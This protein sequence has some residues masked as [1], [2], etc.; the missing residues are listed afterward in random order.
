MYA[1]VGEDRT[2]VVGLSEVTSGHPLRYVMVVRLLAVLVTDRYYGIDLIGKALAHALRLLLPICY[3]SGRSDAINSVLS[4][5]R[6]QGLEDSSLARQLLQRKNKREGYQGDKDNYQGLLYPVPAISPSRSEQNKKKEGVAIRSNKGKPASSHEK[7]RKRKQEKQR[8]GRERGD[9]AKR[10]PHL[11]WPS[12]SLQG[13]Y[14]SSRTEGVRSAAR[15]GRDVT[16]IPSGG[17]ILPEQSLKQGFS[18]GDAL[19][20]VQAAFVATRS[21]ADCLKGPSATGDREEFVKL[22]ST[23]IDSDGIPFVEWEEESLLLANSRYR[24]SLIARFGGRRPTLKEIREWCSKAW[25]LTGKIS[26]AALRKGLIWIHFEC[27][28]DMNKVLEKGQY[29]VGKTAMFLHRWCPGLD[30]DEL[31]LSTWVVW[32]EMSGVPLEL[33]NAWGLK[34]LVLMVGKFIAFDNQTRAL[35][36]PTSVRACCEINARRKLPEEIKVKLKLRGKEQDQETAKEFLK[37]H[38]S[39]ESVAIINQFDH[40]TLEAIMIHVLATVFH[41]VKDYPIVR[42]STLIEQLDSVFRV[43]ADLLKRRLLEIYDN[44]VSTDNPGKLKQ[45]QRTLYEKQYGY[46][47]LMGEFLESRELITINTGGNLNEASL[48]SKKKG[49]KVHEAA[50]KAI[51]TASSFHYKK[52]FS[53]DEASDWYVANV[54]K[55]FTVRNKEEEELINYAVSARHPFQFISTVLCLEFRRINPLLHPVTQDASASAYQLISYFLLNKEL[56]MH[57]NLIP[58]AWFAVSMDLPVFYRIPMFTSVQDYMKTKPV[59]LWVYDRLRKKK[60]QVTLRVTTS[61]RD[62]RKTMAATFVNFIHQKDAGYVVILSDTPKR[63]EIPMTIGNAIS[64]RSDGKDLPVYARILEQVMKKYEEYGDKEISSIFIRIYLSGMKTSVMPILSDDEIAIKIWESI[65]CKVAGEVNEAI[66]IGK[67]KKKPTNYLTALKPTISQ[68]KPFIVADTETLFIDQVHVPYAAGFLVVMP[69]DEVS[70]YSSYK[71]ETYFSEDNIAN[72][73]PTFNERSQKMMY[74]LIERLVVV[75]RQNPSIQ[76]VYFHNF[77]RFDGILLLKYLATY[78]GEKYTIKPLMRNHMLYEIAVYHGKKKLFSLRDSYTLLTSS[79]D[80]L[81]KNLCPQLGC[82]GSIPYDE[83]GVDNLHLLR[84][85][86]L[87]YMKQDILL[88]G[89]VMKKAQEIY[90]GEYHIDLV[91]KL[92]LSSL[93]LTIFRTNYYDEKNWPIYI[94]NRNEDTFIRRGYYGGHSD[95]YIPYGENLYSYDVNSLYP[96]IMKSFPMPGGR[97][98]WHGHLE[99]QNLDNLFGFI[100]AHVVCPSTISRPFLPYRDDNTNTLIFPTGNFVGVYYSEEL[101]Y[102]RDIGYKINPLSGYLFEKMHNSPFG[103]FVSSVFKMRQDA[104]R[105]GNNAMSYVYKILMNSLYGRFGINP[106][107][108]VTE[109]CNLDRYN[110]L[111]M[112]EDFIYADKLSSHYYIVSYLTNTAVA[113]GTDWR[114]P[115]ISAVQL[116]A[117]I[118]ACARIHMYPYISRPDCYYT[119]TDSVVLGSPLPEG[120]ISSTVLGKFKLEH[121]IKKG[122]FLAPK[123]YSF[124]TQE[125]GQILKHKGLAKSLVDETWF[126]LQYADMSRTIQTSL[127]NNFRINWETLNICKKE[128]NVK[129]G[130]RAGTKRLPVYDNDRWVGTE[131]LEVTDYAGQENRIHKYEVKLLKDENIRL[132]EQLNRVMELLSDK[133]KESLEKY[134]GIEYLKSEIENMKSHSAPNTEIENIKLLPAPNT[135]DIKLLPAPNTDDI[136]L[137]SAPNTDNLNHLTNNPKPNE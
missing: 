81:A 89:G 113:S 124:E 106:I 35:S 26:L 25:S 75:V 76:T 68:K 18:L 107:C 100:E 5:Q 37:K 95:T 132:L 86:L 70:S 123:S 90:W 58:T 80:T 111:T 109:I 92:T 64:F 74:E 104:K 85:I 91:N 9:Q 50:V 34:S 13:S 31:L 55:N 99:G 16:S 103:G 66:P 133:E 1:K 3:A 30:L 8:R 79:L 11:L 98:V 116:A 44:S 28:E 96:H 126:E 82:K 108:T 15:R 20:T 49:D 7:Q 84:D 36:R 77:S 22:P 105:M 17:A 121:N 38:L 65:D 118:T 27:E 57:T 56:A 72:L 67:R 24:F 136:K 10:A 73:Y 32:Y 47:I 62:R 78:H 45:G 39:P 53:N 110:H 14:R 33:Y 115:R 130:I 41:S 122:L 21:Y 83:V 63:H 6:A 12:K 101:K 134:R 135:H 19:R 127:Y 46:G 42:L 40:Y 97:P 93:A 23:Q 54:K 51:A 29:R 87:D 102:A 59:N 60:R 120:E 71:I 129:L 119:D 48:P 69:D 128:I 52:F 94:P 4:T 114:P 137:L 2:S 131:P 125:G 43:H 88:L 112:E 117:A 61:K